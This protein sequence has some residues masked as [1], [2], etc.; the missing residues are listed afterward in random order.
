MSDLNNTAQSSPEYTCDYCK[1][2]CTIPLGH[3]R[4]RFAKKVATQPDSECAKDPVASDLLSNQISQSVPT[5]SSDTQSLHLLSDQI[6][7]SQNFSCETPLDSPTTPASPLLTIQADSWQSMTSPTQHLLHRSFANTF[8]EQRE[9]CALIAG[10]SNIPLAEAIAA[11][12]NMPLTARICEQFANTETRVK[13]EENLRNKHVFVIGTGGFRRSGTDPK[14][15]VC[16][17]NDAIMEILIIMNACKLAESKSITVILATYPYAR[18]DKKID[19]R[20]PISGRLVAD[21]LYTAGATRMVCMD[22]HAGQIQGFFSVPVN[23]L[24][25]VIYLCNAIQDIVRP[26]LPNGLT[27]DKSEEFVLCA[28]DAGMSKTIIAYGERL[29]LPFV[30]MHKQRD[31]SQKNKVDK[32]ILI[33]ESDAVRGRTV[34]IIDDIFDTCGTLTQAS[35]TLMEHGAKDI[36]AVGVH[37]VLSGPALDRLNSCDAISRVLVTNTLDQTVNQSFC[38]KITV[39]DISQ[40]LANAVACIMTGQSISKLFK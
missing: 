5:Q 24:Y 38:K 6:P 7:H 15:I 4:C 37:G 21:L 36:I 22:L 14:Q 1:V 11:H 39:V 23:N 29:R 32:T 27:D 13:I 20:E 34:I 26:K 17:V 8:H 35:K 40:L 16:G 10:N 25:S 19:S 31:T 12:L 33:G 3:S 18:Q 9:N 30:I 2:Y 28:P